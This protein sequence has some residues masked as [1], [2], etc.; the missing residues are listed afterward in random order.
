M[1]PISQDWFKDTKE[2]IRQGS[3]S[4]PDSF[5]L[6][7]LLNPYNAK[8][9]SHKF[10]NNRST[11]F[12]ILTF[13]ILFVKQRKSNSRKLTSDKEIIVFNHHLSL[14]SYLKYLGRSQ[15]RVMENSCETS[16]SLHLA[17]ECVWFG[18]LKA[19]RSGGP[20]SHFAERDEGTLRRRLGCLSTCPMS[21]LQPSIQLLPTW[22]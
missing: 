9:Q 18:H 16:I 11:H 15:I 6:V 13:I 20:A 19:S 5:L 4:V 7:L 14:L 1:P 8:V 21:S 12:I 10:I 17:L 22:W 2:T 3:N